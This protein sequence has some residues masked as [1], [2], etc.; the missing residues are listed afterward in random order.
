MKHAV[1]LLG[2]VLLA[3]CSTIQPRVPASTYTDGAKVY[4]LRGHSM[5]PL[6]CDG[7]RIYVD[8][9]YPYDA[10]RAGDLVVYRNARSA[11]GTTC[12]MLYDQHCSGGAWRTYGINNLTIDPWIMT[13]EDYIGKVIKIE[14]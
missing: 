8:T 14:K 10:L 5:E 12:H 13:R 9:G 2:A 11:Q 7:Y 3:G 6:I 4:T 1:M